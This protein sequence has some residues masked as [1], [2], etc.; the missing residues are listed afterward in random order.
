MVARSFVFPHRCGNE[1]FPNAG[2][3]IH[4]ELAAAQ[5]FG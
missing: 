2:L 3:Y 4:D 5:M 1:P